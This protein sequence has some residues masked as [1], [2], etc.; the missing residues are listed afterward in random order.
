MYPRGSPFLLLT[1]G[2]L[3]IWS[4]GC[5]HFALKSEGKKSK[6]I[7]P[8][9]LDA[10]A[11]PPRP[12]PDFTEDPSAIAY[13]A[14][15]ILTGPRNWQGTPEADGLYVSLHPMDRENRL[16]RKLGSFRFDLYEQDFRR[17]DKKGRHIMRWV[18]SSEEA[19]RHWKPGRF[20]GYHFYLRWNGKA[21]RIKFGVLESRFFPSEGTEFLAVDTSLRISE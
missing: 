12:S 5:D 21:P 9:A 1:L 10:A 20:G 15:G 19:V 14:T 2:L 18:V 6:A 8:S 16:V 4:P 11:A 3:L 17:V 13:L 7:G